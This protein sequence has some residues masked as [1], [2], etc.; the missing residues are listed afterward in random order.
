MD[1]DQRLLVESTGDFLR[2]WCTPA[3]LRGRDATG[4]EER[5]KYWRDGA[6]LGW[7][8]M[9][10]PPSAGG[11][12]VSGN[13]VVDLMLLVHQFGK[14][15]APGALGPTNV[16]IAGL[17]TSDDP[18]RFGGVIEDLV[19][20]RATA[21]WGPS[22]AGETSRVTAMSQGDSVILSGDLGVLEVDAA[23]G[24]VLVCAREGATDLQILVPLNS[25]G[26]HVT[27]LHSLDL[28][29]CFVRVELREIVASRN[30]VVSQGAVAR[31]SEAWLRDLA[32]L[33]QL[34][35]FV[36]AMQW[37][38][39]TTM[40]W[41]AD[42]YSFGRSLSSYQEIKHR[43]ADMKMWLDASYAITREAAEAVAEDTEN[44]S[45]LVSAGKF[46]IGTY[47][48]EL[49]HDSVQMHGGIGLTAEHDLHVYIR[50]V[51]ANVPMLGHP[52]VHAARLGDMAIAAGAQA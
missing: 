37:A 29:R 36:G 42:R 21:T 43:L 47:A 40:S 9:L 8:A 32:C 6:E 7:T 25:P 41:C 5:S 39:E 44:R 4:P 48:P 23:T 52:R 16:V 18:T 11:G 34:A 30:L 27:E 50:R 20:G 1:P 33:I 51:S 35:E 22:G 45:A 28:T 31:R 2:G 19:A 24:H 12:S 49:M 3:R 15:A 26:A 14:H 38:F 13:G 17:N 46:Y 10:A